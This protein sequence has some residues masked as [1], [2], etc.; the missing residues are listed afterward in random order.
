V[1]GV[2]PQSSQQKKNAMTFGEGKKQKR[3]KSDL[4]MG[5]AEKL[6]VK[7]RRVSDFWGG[8]GWV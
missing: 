1:C 5:T 4:S 3:E 7:L 2:M 6:S 8:A